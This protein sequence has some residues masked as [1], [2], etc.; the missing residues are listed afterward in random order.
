MKSQERSSSQTPLDLTWDA[1]AGQHQPARQHLPQ[2][3]AQVPLEEYFAFL[4][5]VRA[6]VGD[7]HANSTPDVAFVLPGARAQ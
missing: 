1:T 6:G 3:R 7:T 4:A 2:S 5:E